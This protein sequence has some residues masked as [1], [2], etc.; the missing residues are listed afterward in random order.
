MINLII[1]ANHAMVLVKIVMDLLML[2]AFNV[3]ILSYK[4]DNVLLNV[5]MANVKKY[6]IILLLKK[7][8]PNKKKIKIK[9]GD[10]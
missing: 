10:L 4:L 7:N 9:D 6:F 5:K 1:L 8:I 3:K 2:I